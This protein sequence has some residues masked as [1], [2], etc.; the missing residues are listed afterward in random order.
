ML[1]DRVTNACLLVRKVMKAWEATDPMMTAGFLLE[2]IREE[3]VGH[4]SQLY[5]TKGM[6][7]HFQCVSPT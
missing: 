4:A 3:Q 5:K 6:V 1:Y 7:R 2:L